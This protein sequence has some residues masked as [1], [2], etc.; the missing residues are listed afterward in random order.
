M[1]K[2][3]FDTE[4]TGLFQ[5]AEL[6][7]IGLVDEY[8]C[9]F[10]AEFNDFNKD[11]VGEWVKE[12]VIAKLIQNKYNGFRFSDDPRYMRLYNA[13]KFQVPRALKTY[14][15]YILKDSGEDYIQLVSD[16][17]YYDMVL[18]QGIFGGAFSVPKYVSPV[19]HDI[20]TDLA[21]YLGIHEKEA[22]DLSRINCCKDLRE[23]AL[24]KVPEDVIYDSN[25]QHNALLD[26]RLIKGIAEALEALTSLD[27]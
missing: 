22:F 7:S 5:G 8:G 27:K 26:A 16:V 17:C 2:V 19:C 14:F 1:L 6:I 24:L 25:A 20:N 15:K 9:N 23:K 10:Y 18:F 13:N 12:N 21:Q 11:A 4:F 3:Y